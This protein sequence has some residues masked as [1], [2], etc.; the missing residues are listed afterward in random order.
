YPGQCLTLIQK[1][2]KI[3]TTMLAAALLFSACK[4]DDA[5]EVTANGIVILAEGTDCPVTI[6]L[7]SGLKLAPINPD[8]EH[9]KPMLIHNRRVSVSYELSDDFLTPCPNAEPA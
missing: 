3:I 4:K 1:Q 7:D 5:E 6:S 9:V 8:E 2:M